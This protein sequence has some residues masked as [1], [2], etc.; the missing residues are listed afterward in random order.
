VQEESEAAVGAIEAGSQSVAGGVEL[1][2]EAGSSL[3]EITRA[4]RESGTRIGEIVSAVREQTKATGHVVSLMEAVREGVDHIS[5]ARTEQD[6]ANEVVYRSSVTMQEVAQ[7]VRRT[8]EEQSRGFGRIRES[9]EG[10]REAVEQINGSLRD[11]SSACAQ[12]AEFLEQVADGTRSNEDA[13]QR[14]GDS[15]RVMMEQAEALRADLEEF[16]L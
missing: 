5:L 1:S 10:V 3:E 2:A 13:A 11:Q 16:R 9:I 6:G 14:M 15:M 12:V 4:S 7:Q 8:T